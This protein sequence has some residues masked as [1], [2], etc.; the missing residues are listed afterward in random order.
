[1]TGS[2]KRL[3]GGRFV[4]PRVRD[5]VMRLSPAQLAALFESLDWRRVRPERVARPR[6]AG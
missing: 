6:A 5:G 1:M 3:E 2:S 4:W